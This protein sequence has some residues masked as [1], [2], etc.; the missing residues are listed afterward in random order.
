ME[1]INKIIRKFLTLL[2]AIG[3]N[4]PI[5]MQTGLINKNFVENVCLNY[6]GENF[7]FTA[8]VNGIFVYI[9]YSI[10]LENWFKTSNITISR[11]CDIWE[12]E[13]PS[14]KNIIHYENIPV[15][16]IKSKFKK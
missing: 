13:I 3:M 7:Y 1:W 8:I 10:D 4:L 6:D 16:T 2:K 12:M 9:N 15:T 11:L 5:D 14:D